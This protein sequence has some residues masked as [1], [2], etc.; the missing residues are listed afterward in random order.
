MLSRWLSVCPQFDYV[1][2]DRHV[3]ASAFG[4]PDNLVLTRNIDNS[5]ARANIVIVAVKPQSI[6]ATVPDIVDVLNDDAA[7]V[8]VMAGV[9][10]QQLGTWFGTSHGC[11]RAMPNTP[12][13]VGQGV[14]VAMCDTHVTDAVTAK[15]D[16]LFNAL[17]QT[18]WIDDEAQFDAITAIGGSGPAYVF[19]FIEA[20]TQAGINAGIPRD[21]AD[22]LARQTVIGG[23]ALAD[24]FDLSPETLR[25]NVTS[26]GGVT[27]EALSVLMDGRLQDIMSEAIAKAKAKSEKMI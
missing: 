9:S 4:V 14:T 2:V 27:A 21:H 25:Q 18:L 17:G 26:K 3:E 6:A 15:M 22:L 24:H 13:A 12:S 8:S 11:V 7:I 5:L 10:L 16:A 1:V 19:Y 23:A 20:L